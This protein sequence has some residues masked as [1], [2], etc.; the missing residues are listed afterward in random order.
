M[1][2]VDL[3]PKTREWLDNLRPRDIE[4][5]EAAIKLYRDSQT[6]KRF[7]KWAALIIISG[8]AF[9]TQISEYLVKVLALVRGKP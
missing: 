9:A 1:R 5:Y 7:W 8:F 3:P 4:D 6:L 2:Y